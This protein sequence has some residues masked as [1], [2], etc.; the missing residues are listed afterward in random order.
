[1]DTRD[2]QESSTRVVF[3]LGDVSP[4]RYFASVVMVLS[5]LLALLAPEDDGSL[6]RDLIV[7]VLQVSIPMTVAIV[8]HRQLDRGAGFRRLG[9]WW[10]LTV[11]GAIASLIFAPMAVLIDRLVVG[12]D[13]P[14]SVAEIA[15]ELGAILPAVILVWLA[16]NAPWVLGFRV[17]QRGGSRPDR[18]TADTDPPSSLPPFLRLVPLRVR[19]E[20]I[21]LKSELH[22]LEVITTAGRSLVLYNLRDAMAELAP[23][24]GIQ[25]H[26][27]H[28]V[29][30]AH[31]QDL[32]RRG[33]EGVLVLSDG[34]EVPVSRG[35]LKAVTAFCDG[36]PL[37][38]GG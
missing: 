22:Y 17:V 11:S 18:P 9:R 19:G 21:R 10:Q 12:E 5:A 35:R 20:V 2:E 28:W 31:I 3:P 25:T 4:R 16:V 6:L 26:R 32:Q 37:T 23:D 30:G 13:E 33:R 38:T 34:S 36:L 24:T 27:S 8:A 29:A 1:M 15:S 7:W 14:F